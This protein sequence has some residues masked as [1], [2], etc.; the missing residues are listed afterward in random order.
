[1]INT[2]WITLALFT[3]TSSGGSDSLPH[4]LSFLHTPKFEIRQWVIFLCAI[5]MATGIAT[6]WMADHPHAGS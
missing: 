3:G 1:V 4:W 2:A 6:G 5:T